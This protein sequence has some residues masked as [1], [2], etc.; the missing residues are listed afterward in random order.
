MNSPERS[1]ELEEDVN[2]GSNTRDSE[3]EDNLLSN[4]AGLWPEKITD[5]D[6]STIVRKL[7]TT[8]DED[9][10]MPQDSVGKPF[11]DYLRHTRS[12][13]GREKVKRDWLTHSKSTNALYCIPCVLFSHEQ[14][15]VQ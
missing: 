15:K 1:V 12:A 6:R 8:R 10:Q 9:L 13:N 7:A 3:E 4:D 14:K 2:S 5:K 11:P